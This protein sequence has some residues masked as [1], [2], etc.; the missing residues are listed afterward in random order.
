MKGPGRWAGATIG[1][2]G[3]LPHGGPTTEQGMY[4]AAILRVQ[5]V[6]LDELRRINRVLERLAPKEE[7]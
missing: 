6:M 3:P 7:R 4:L 5:S 2:L 1:D